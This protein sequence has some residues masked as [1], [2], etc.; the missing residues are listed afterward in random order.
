MKW[1]LRVVALATVCMI[2][3]NFVCAQDGG[4]T[5]EISSLHSVLQQLYDDMI[6]LCSELIGVGRGIAGFAATWYIAARVWRHVA[7][8]EPVDFYPLFR[9]FVL[10]FAVLIFPSTLDIINGIM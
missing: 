2:I 3:P 1:C 5:S 6:P 4:I 8:A 9:P 7:N 10:G